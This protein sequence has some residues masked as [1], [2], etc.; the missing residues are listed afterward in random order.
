MQVN[1]T[2]L[3]APLKAA[4]REREQSLMLEKLK[5]E[6][7]KIPK[8]ERNEMI[9]MIVSSLASLNVDFQRAFKSLF[10]TNALDGSEDYL[11]KVS[12]MP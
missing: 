8:P 11:V 3:H 9:E 6:P 7:N 12:N 2:D 4:Y 1:D 10:V 5:K